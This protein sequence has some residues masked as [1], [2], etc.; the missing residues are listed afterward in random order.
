MQYLLARPSSPL[1]FFVKQYWA[2]ENCFSAG[3]HLERI[4][5]TGLPVLYFYLSDKP[6]LIQANSQDHLKHHAYLCGQYNQFFDLQVTGN[7]HLFAVVFQ[8]YAL[9]MIF[10]IPSTELVNDQISLQEIYPQ[11]GHELSSKIGDAISFAERVDIIETFIFK[12]LKK[13]PEHT[14]MARLRSSINIISQEN[15]FNSAQLAANACLS[16]KQFE[17]VFRQFIGLPPHKFIRVLR[18]QKSLLQKQL[19]PGANLTRV[20]IEAGYFDQSHMIREFKN[21]TGMTPKKYFSVCIPHSDFF[22]M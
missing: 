16:R 19:F 9:S 2:M 8:P 15:Y 7:M 4:I 22:M 3:V 12:Q 17:R 10:G 18:L 11:L 5:P 6:V 1:Q 20:A 21:L 14:H 13:K